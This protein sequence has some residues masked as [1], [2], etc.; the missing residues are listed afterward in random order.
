MTTVSYIEGLSTSHRPLP[1]DALSLH[2]DLP[3][4]VFA[5]LRSSAILLEDLRVPT[6]IPNKIAYMRRGK[7]VVNVRRLKDSAVPWGL[8]ASAMGDEVSFWLL[9]YES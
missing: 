3:N 2:H 5:G 8:L 4:L 1:S 9:Q 7:A 6:K